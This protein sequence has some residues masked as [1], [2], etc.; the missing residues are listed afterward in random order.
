[1][2]PEPC[3]VSLTH[4]ERR[5]LSFFLSYD[6]YQLAIQLESALR[7]SNRVARPLEQLKV[8]DLRCVEQVRLIIRQ[9]DGWAFGS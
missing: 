9:T 5:Y 2:V 6:M 7:A 8:H 4:A 3:L 1:M